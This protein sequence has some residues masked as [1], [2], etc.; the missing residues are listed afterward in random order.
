[1]DLVCIWPLEGGAKI[2]SGENISPAICRQASQGKTLAKGK[3]H[4]MLVMVGG[5]GDGRVEPRSVRNAFFSCLDAP[6]LKNGPR[7][8]LIRL[9][10]SFADIDECSNPATC[11][12]GVTCR[13]VPGSFECGCP[14]GTYSTRPYVGPVDNVVCSSC[15]LAAEVYIFSLNIM[16]TLFNLLIYPVSP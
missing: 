6:G 5:R 15:F 9:L 2:S 16:T 13:N 1:M 3:I 7:R 11:G 4:E 14:S 8:D 10:P 12:F